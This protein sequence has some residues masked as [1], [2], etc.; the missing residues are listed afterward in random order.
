MDERLGL[1]GLQYPIPEHANKLAYSLGGLTLITFV[2][3]VATG[4]YLTQYYNP[5]PAFA[6]ES[7]RNIITSGSAGKFIRS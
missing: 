6:H 1:E 3:M 4:I 2:L 7:V 5:D